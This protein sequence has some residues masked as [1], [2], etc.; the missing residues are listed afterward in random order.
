MRYSHFIVGV[1][2]VAATA[3]AGCRADQQV[4]E[5]GTNTDRTST[6]RADDLTLPAGTS[7]EVTLATPI[8]SKTA[9]VGDS[10]TG[11]TR[12]ALTLDGKNVIPAGSS[13]TG[14]VTSVQAA[15]KGD[16][17]MLDLGLTSIAVGSRSYRVRG[18]TE[19]VVAGSTRA[20]N[21]GAIA[22]SAAGGALI[23][24]AVSGTGKG[25]VIGGIIGGGVATGVVAKSD[26]FQVVLKPGTAITFTT[27]EAVAV[28]L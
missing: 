21:L 28:R 16:R 1:A 22:G 18:S 27:S 17:A 15:R 19:S 4:A 5:N 8:S 10:W 11:S 23:G 14:T 25:A 26:G 13:V 9:S 6:Y 7:V 12:N 2:L 24:K 20:R 3:L